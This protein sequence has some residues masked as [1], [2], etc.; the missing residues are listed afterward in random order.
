MY[1]LGGLCGVNAGSTPV[2]FGAIVG[3]RLVVCE[4]ITLNYNSIQ[5][6]NSMRDKYVE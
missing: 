3:W 4:G 1:S 5:S 2:V 6:Y